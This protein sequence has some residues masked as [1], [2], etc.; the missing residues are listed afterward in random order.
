[1]SEQPRDEPPKY[2]KSREKACAG[3][4]SLNDWEFRQP[5]CSFHTPEKESELQ[6][7]LHS[8]TAE[9]VTRPV[10]HKVS[11]R[12][13]PG[14]CELATLM[15]MLVIPEPEPE[16]L[17]ASVDIVGD[18]RQARDSIRAYRATQSLQMADRLPALHRPMFNP[19]SATF[20]EV[21]NLTI[22]FSVDAEN[23]IGRRLFEYFEL[24]DRGYYNGSPRMNYELRREFKDTCRFDF[25]LMRPLMFLP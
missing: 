1:M 20:P 5:V 14:I 16:E 12:R 25:N 9:F 7:R 2:P 4:G 11:G 10:V 13:P 18:T 15:E 3:C 22:E 24:V 23:E 8:P 19:P 6:T 21:A 17:P